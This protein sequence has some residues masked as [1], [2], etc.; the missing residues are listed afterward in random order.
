MS[1]E[2]TALLDFLD[3]AIREKHATVEIT[4]TFLGSGHWQV[5][6]KSTT[7]LNYMT[8]GGNTLRAALES[9]LANLVEKRLSIPT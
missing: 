4:P 7:T 3:Q 8:G 2:D 5:A 1:A 6:Y 9:L